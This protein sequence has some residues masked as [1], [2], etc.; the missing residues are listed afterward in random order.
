L[1]IVAVPGI[2]NLTM[3]FSGTN[4]FSP[5]VKLS[6]RSVDDQAIESTYA[7]LMVQRSPN[8]VNWIDRHYEANPQASGIWYR[9]RD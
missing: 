7:E 2:P 6:L 3:S 9:A 4:P 1:T 8:L 5:S